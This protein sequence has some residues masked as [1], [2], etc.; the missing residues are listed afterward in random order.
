MRNE[1]A[2]VKAPPTPAARPPPAHHSPA[3]IR[4]ARSS[5]GSLPGTRSPTS[6]KPSRQTGPGRSPARSS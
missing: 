4:S 3:R 2:I 6:W 1:K 5:R